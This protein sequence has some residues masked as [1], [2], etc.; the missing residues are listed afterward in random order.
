MPWIIFQVMIL[1]FYILLIIGS[2]FFWILL[3]FEVISLLI[4]G[5]MFLSIWA[6]RYSIY[7]QHIL[8][9]ATEEKN[10]LVNF[11]FSFPLQMKSFVNNE[12]KNYFQTGNLEIKR[13][14][15][16][17]VDWPMTSDHVYML[18]C[19]YRGLP[20]GLGVLSINF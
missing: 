1:I 6:L 13:R 5:Y 12:S 7:F 10:Y 19:S 17:W 8:L 20:L 16:E 14:R 2:I 3:P 9:Q 18:C 15:G 11:L 4:Y